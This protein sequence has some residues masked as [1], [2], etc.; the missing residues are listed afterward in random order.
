MFLKK[1]T[2]QRTQTGASGISASSNRLLLRYCG[3]HFEQ[4]GHC[5]SGTNSVSIIGVLKVRGL[6]QQVPTLPDA[7]VFGRKQRDETEDRQMA[8]TVKVFNRRRRVFLRCWS[9]AYLLIQSIKKFR[10]FRSW[11]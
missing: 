7:A 11:G 3:S 5:A 10:N 2:V 4:T 8:T 1:A 9:F 6:G